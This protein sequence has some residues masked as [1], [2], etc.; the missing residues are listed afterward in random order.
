[1]ATAMTVAEIN[2]LN[3][4]T[5][6]LID[7]SAP[8]TCLSLYFLW[9]SV[10]GPAPALRLAHPVMDES[11][12][13]VH[14]SG[15]LL[16]R[17]RSRGGEFSQVRET[18]VHPVVTVVVIRIVILSS[19]I[20]VGVVVFVVVIAVLL[21]KA[22]EGRERQMFPIFNLFGDGLQPVTDALDGVVAQQQSQGRVAAVAQ[23]PD[24]LGCFDAA[25]RLVLAHPL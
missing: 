17:G 11:Y 20:I 18:V 4:P 1:M 2:R 19:G 3:E 13:H 25:H 6:S 22:L 7:L 5:V 9:C 10:H 8:G 15:L 24:Q 16:D 23:L 12:R 14:I 21:L